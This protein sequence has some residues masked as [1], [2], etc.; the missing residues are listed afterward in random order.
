[1]NEET[2][3]EVM[4][5]KRQEVIDRESA[6]LALT[7]VALDEL[8]RSHVDGAYTG[9]TDKDVNTIT[10]MMEDIN[11]ELSILLPDEMNEW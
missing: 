7:F 2:H 11:I 9:L 6:K 3:E 4:R 8:Y 10:E 5:R 1:M